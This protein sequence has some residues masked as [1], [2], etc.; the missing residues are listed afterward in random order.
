MWERFFSLYSV[1]PL[2]ITYEEVV[3][4]IVGIVYGISEYLS[5][6]IV[7]NVTG[8]DVCT[9]KMADEINQEWENRIRSRYKIN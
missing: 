6:E 9:M 7:K 1:N 4:D 8:D 5:V 3:E 2:M